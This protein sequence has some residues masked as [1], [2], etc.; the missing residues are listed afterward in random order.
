MPV[1]PP[2]SRPLTRQTPQRNLALV[3]PK[4]DILE[5][6][7]KERKRSPLEAAFL[8]VPPMPDTAP[9]RRLLRPLPATG[10]RFPFGLPASP[11][12]LPGCLSY[13]VPAPRGHVVKL[14]SSTN[15]CRIRHLQFVPP[16]KTTTTANNRRNHPAV[17]PRREARLFARRSRLPAPS[18]P[19]ASE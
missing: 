2:H 5:I 12:Q 11:F 10:S 13:R 14:A 18:P 4:L 15:P 17:A 19:P 1:M 16:P 8:F 6:E 3:F 9:T 7:G